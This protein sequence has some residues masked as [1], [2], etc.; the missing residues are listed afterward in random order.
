M[1]N[2]VICLIFFSIF[3][4]IDLFPIYKKK[5]WNYFWFY[6]IILI[7]SFSITVLDHLDIEVPS[8][9]GPIEKIVRMVFNLKKQ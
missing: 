9:A 5:R 7:I 4:V 6:T 1:E 3:I 2:I 8:P